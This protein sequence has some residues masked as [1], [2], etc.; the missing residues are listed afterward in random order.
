MFLQRLKSR[1]EQIFIELVH[2][3]TERRLDAARLVRGGANHDIHPS[4]WVLRSRN[5]KLRK[6]LSRERFVTRTAY[7][8][9]DFLRWCRLF[10]F[11]VIEGDGLTNCVARGEVTLS[12]HVVHDDDR[13]RVLGVTRIKCA[14]AQQRRSHRA[15]I[16]R[17]DREMGTR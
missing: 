9:D 7:D 2:D 3:V 8:A 16:I 6:R 14:P 17:R 13:S 11:T 4:G 5:V 1:S 10:I 15:E 12:Q